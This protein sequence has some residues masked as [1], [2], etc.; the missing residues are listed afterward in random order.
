MDGF[1]KVNDTLI[2]TSR[3]IAVS[4]EQAQGRIAEHYLAVFDTGQTLMLSIE[5]GA[6]LMSN[7]QALN[8]CKPSA[9]MMATTSETAI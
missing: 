2:N 1:I 8:L 9:G 3:L 4:R 5:E 6:A 7:Y